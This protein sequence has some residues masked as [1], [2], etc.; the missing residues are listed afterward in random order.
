RWRGRHRP[1]LLVLEFQHTGIAVTAQVQHVEIIFVERFLTEFRP[2]H[3]QKPDLTTP[4]RL[5][6]LDRIENLLQFALVVVHARIGL[7]FVG[8]ADRHQDLERVR[9]CVGCRKTGWPRAARCAPEIDI[10]LQRDSAAIGQLQQLERQSQQPRGGR[11]A[12]HLNGG[13]QRCTVDQRREGLV[14]LDG[15]TECREFAGQFLL[16]APRLGQGDVRG[17]TQQRPARATAKLVH[18]IY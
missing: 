17:I 13:P 15:E 16:F 7:S 14:G 6:L 2:T 12:H 11:L 1:S 4:L 10:R 8:S 9:Q 18:P 3:L 5:W